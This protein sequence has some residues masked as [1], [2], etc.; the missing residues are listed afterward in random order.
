MKIPQMGAVCALFDWHGELRISNNRIVR[1]KDFA[2]LPAPFLA[3]AS[4]PSCLIP[5]SMTR[6][7]HTSTLLHL[8]LLLPCLSA[9]A[10]HVFAD[11]IHVTSGISVAP[12]STNDLFWDVDNNGVVDF[13]FFFFSFGLGSRDL[14][15]SESVPV[16][17]EGQIIT[18]AGKVVSLPTRFEVDGTLPDG[19]TWTHSVPA[20]TTGSDLFDHLSGFAEN[21][22]GFV[23]IRFKSSGSTLYGWGKLAVT[24]GPLDENG[25]PTVPGLAISEWAWETSGGPILIPVPEP[26]GAILLTMATV[27]TA[28]R[29][30]RRR[31]QRMLPQPATPAPA[32]PLGP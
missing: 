2:H 27:G 16:T 6:F 29:H 4:P 32:V 10:T 14:N 31:R 21:T 30:R 18:A 22:P 17:A 26:S 19:F 13:Q 8:L 28:L 11:V 20:L 9:S 24:L 23:G 1:L 5:P 3:A 7:R 12:G 25:D 15:Y